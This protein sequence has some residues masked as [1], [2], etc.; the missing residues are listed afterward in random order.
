MDAIEFAK[1]V[2]KICRSHPNCVECEF[3]RVPGK[4]DLTSAYANHEVMV[5][6]ADQWVKEH[7][8]EVTLAELTTIKSD[9]DEL[10][11]RFKMVI[12]K[13]NELIAFADSSISF[14]FDSGCEASREA[15]RESYELA[16]ELIEKYNNA[17]DELEEE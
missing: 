14:D 3:A 2:R 10:E 13:I 12:E 7:T 6:V 4:C 16:R 11:A 8:R 1:T 9:R 15:A 17:M 5:S